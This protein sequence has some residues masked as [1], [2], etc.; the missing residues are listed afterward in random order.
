MPEIENAICQESG[1]FR[2]AEGMRLDPFEETPHEYFCVKHAHEN[3]Y[4]YWCCLFY[5]G[6]SSFDFSSSGLCY[7]CEQNMKAEYEYEYD[8]WYEY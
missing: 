1:C 2:E 7:E 3:G 5:S 6:I 4:C 8:D